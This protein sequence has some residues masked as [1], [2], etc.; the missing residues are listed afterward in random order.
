MSIHK[1]GPTRWSKHRAGPDHEPEM[2]NMKA[3]TAFRNAGA[4]EEMIAS[5]RLIF[6]SLPREAPGRPRMYKKSKEANHAF[7][8]RHRDRHRK[9]LAISPNNGHM[10]ATGGDP[11]TPELSDQARG[12]SAPDVGV[13][14]NPPV[15]TP[16][17]V[18]AMV[19]LHVMLVD[20][21][22]WNVDS[23]ADVEPM[24]RLMFDKGC[25]LEADVLPTVARMVPELPRPL[26]N[27][28]AQWLV[29]EI[30]A[31][32]DQRLALAT[33]KPGEGHGRGYRRDDSRCRAKS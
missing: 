4:T 1:S 21:A 31:A 2:E 26:K 33:W 27:W 19:A 25:D 6:G 32:P 22:R 3:I 10:K 30:M 29:R 14:S 23:D 12:G 16:N 18:K 11:A 8:I 28:G 15:A 20:A 17:P 13:A 24:R 5:A 7:Y 9:M